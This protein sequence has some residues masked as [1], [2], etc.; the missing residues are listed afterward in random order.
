MIIN[1]PA[2]VRL[3]TRADSYRRLNALTGVR[4]PKTEL[5]TISSPPETLASVVEEAG[6]E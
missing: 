4:M 1:P 5:F 2:R 3:T 6:F